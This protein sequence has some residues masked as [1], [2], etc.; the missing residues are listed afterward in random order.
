MELMKLAMAQA[1]HEDTKI[2]LPN[3]EATDLDDEGFLK[4]I[5]DAIGTVRKTA[6]QTLYKDS[7]FKLFKYMNEYAKFKS[8]KMK[9]IAQ[10]RR[11]EHFDTNP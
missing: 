7:F 1:P 11:C 6:K 10:Q 5:I 3:I 8:D 9:K 4:A 2:E